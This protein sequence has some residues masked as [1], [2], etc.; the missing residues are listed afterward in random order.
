MQ[1]PKVDL[2]TICRGAA[3]PLFQNSLEAVN[4]NIK[5]PNT[6]VAKKRKITLQAALN[7]LLFC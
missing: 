2:F 6:P 7:K 4:T 3:H 5:D 1:A